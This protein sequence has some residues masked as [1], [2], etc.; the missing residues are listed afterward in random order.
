MYYRCC[1]K[2]HSQLL[3]KDFE[4]A[5]MKPSEVQSCRVTAIILQDLREAMQSCQASFKQKRVVNMTSKD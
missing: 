5:M 3:F 1:H 2:A 4:A